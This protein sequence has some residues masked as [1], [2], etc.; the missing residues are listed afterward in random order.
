LK[1]VNLNF[2]LEKIFEHLFGPEKSSYYIV[3]KIMHE[4]PKKRNGTM[5]LFRYFFLWNKKLN[6]SVPYFPNKGEWAL[7][8]T[9]SIILLCFVLNNPNNRF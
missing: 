9:N 7:D 3:L 8:G 5:L 1:R 6:I 2:T 4:Y